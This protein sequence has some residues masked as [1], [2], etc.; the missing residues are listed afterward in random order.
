MTS[1]VHVREQPLVWR[2]ARGLSHGASEKEWETAGIGGV[3]RKK[4]PKK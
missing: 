3:A 4:L 2:K 1:V